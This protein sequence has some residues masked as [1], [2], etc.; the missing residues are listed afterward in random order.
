MTL[1]SR[2]YLARFQRIAY[3]FMLVTLAFNITYIF[4]LQASRN[5][6]KGVTIHAPIPNPG[7]F[8]IPEKYVSVVIQ[9]AANYGIP[10]DIAI[11]LVYEESRWKE[12]AI[13]RNDNGTF[14]YG[15]MQ[16]N[17]RYFDIYPWQ[18]NVQKG[19]AHLAAL[20]KQ[21]GTWRQA[22]VSYNAGLNGGKNPPQRS[23]RY[24]DR[25]VKG[26]L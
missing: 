7:R 19:L 20:Y 3:I 17:S 24:A 23:V 21:T 18:V 5:P 10:L 14:D 1:R 15:L 12:K 2:L 22:L 13:N 9:E 11:R 6:L 8:L 4:H 26:G 25:I 16:L